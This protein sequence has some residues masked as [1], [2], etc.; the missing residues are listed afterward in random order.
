MYN[1]GKKAVIAIQSKDT[2]TFFKKASDAL[3]NLIKKIPPDTRKIIK[4]TKNVA[5]DEICSWK[6]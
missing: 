2:K 1:D 5:I 3:L 6:E 4:N